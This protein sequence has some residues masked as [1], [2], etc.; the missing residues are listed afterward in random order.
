MNKNCKHSVFPA[1]D[2]KF[3]R[4]TILSISFESKLIRSFFHLLFSQALKNLVGL[5]CTNWICH[6]WWKKIA[7]MAQKPLANNQYGDA[8]P[9][10]W[11]FIT[12]TVISNPVLAN[13]PVSHPLETPENLWFSRVFRGYKIA[14]N[15]NQKWV[16]LRTNL[17]IFR[18]SIYLLKVNNRNARIRC[19]ICSKLTI[20]TPERCHWSHSGVILF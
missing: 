9:M 14:G 15:I 16:T 1:K 4:L 8:S 7:T 10:H 17:K 11:W 19:E 2:S 5:R 20:K 3:H 12:F 6:V 13:S 18:V